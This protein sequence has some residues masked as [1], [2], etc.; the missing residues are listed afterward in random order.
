MINEEIIKDHLKKVIE[1]KSSKDVIALGIVSSIIIKEG[2]VSFALEIDGNTKENEE[3][4]KNCEQAVKDIPGATKVTVVATSATTPKQQK[5][6]LHIEGVKNIIVVAS[7]KGGVGKSTVALNLALSLARLKHKVA[8]LDA[9]I[10]GPSIP[11]MLGAEELK[12]EVLGGKVIPIEKYGLHTISIGYFIDKDRAAIWRGPMITKALH[13]LLMGTKWPDIEYLIIDT[14]PGTGDVHL[15]LME[16]F[17]LTGA[18]IVSTPQELALIDA[19]KIYDMF[20]KLSVPVIGIVENMS[21][22]IQ[23]S[24]KIYIFGKDG[25]KKMSEELGI[26]LLG[27][28]PID[29]QICQACDCGDPSIL[30]QNLVEIYDDIA[31]GILVLPIKEKT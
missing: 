2:H 19:R 10:Y 29:P 17:H 12:P 8:L 30:S 26:T 11:K 23:N 28:I 1:Q 6:K 13:N 9:D 25:A 5:A 24:S 21:Y 7:G 4:R 3:L 16:N 22:F 31:K 15:S 27:S 18:I 14:P 20:T